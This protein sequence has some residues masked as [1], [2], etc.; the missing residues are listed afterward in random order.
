[1]RRILFVALVPLLL[2]CKKPKQ[3]A[4]PD[5]PPGPPKVGHSVTK[6]KEDGEPAGSGAHAGS[7]SAAVAEPPDAPPG[8]N[9]GG[10]GSPAFRDG[11]GRVHGPGGPVFMGHGVDCDAA[12]DHCMRPD[13]WFSVANIIPGKLFR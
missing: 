10:D 9:L 7:G 8:A 2:S 13:V 3:E 1:M 11:N 5:P 6:V 4:E 12:H